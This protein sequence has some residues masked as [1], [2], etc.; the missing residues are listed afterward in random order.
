MIKGSHFS[1]EI[2]KKL[3]LAR[4]GKPSPN[5]GRKLSKEWKENLSKSLKGHPKSLE[6]RQRL[7]K[8]RMGISPSLEIREKIR[9]TLT[10]R[11]LSVEHKK[12]ISLG[13]KQLIGSLNPLWKGDKVGY[14]TLHQWVEK[15]KGKPQYCNFMPIHLH[16]K[17]Q[18]A[19]IS[20]KYKR[21]LDDWMSL[22]ISC[23]SKYDRNYRKNIK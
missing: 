9:Q 3:S 21:D 2:R 11:K 7:S 19:N 15:Y 8:S 6:M 14:R 16:R 4:I 22:C 10:G 5:K 13:S 17:Y 12:N 20:H 23:H 18:W 1:D